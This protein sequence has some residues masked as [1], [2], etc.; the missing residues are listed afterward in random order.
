MGTIGGG[1]V[2]GDPSQDPPPTLIALGASATLTSANGERILPVEDLFI[3]YYETDV[4]PGEVLT[5]VS[6]PPAPPG[7]GSCY[8]KF[9]P[10]TADDY[11]TVS[12]AALVEPSENNVCRDVRIVLGSVGVTPVRAVD[13]ESALRGRE[14]TGAN[15]RACAEAVREAVDPLEDFRGSPEYKTDMA[16]VFTRR[17]IEQALAKAG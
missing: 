3:D 11:A 2:H 9:L 13:A 7:S 14:L 1:L 10:R 6:I 16:E 15:I 17:A 8:I 5:R 12:V 4:Q